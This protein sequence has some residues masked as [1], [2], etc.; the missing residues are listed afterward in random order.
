MNI[1][2]NCD[3]NRGIAQTAHSLAKRGEPMTELALDRC[4]ALSHVSDPDALIR[5]GGEARIS[6][7]LLQQSI[8]TEHY[9]S[10]LLRPGLDERSLDD[11]IGACQKRERR[12]G[13]TTVQL[14]QSLYKHPVCSVTRAA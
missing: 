5:T 6:N 12:F 13:Q 3:G 10:T 11:A 1:C 9:F 4:M 7:F 8:D 14:S 2:L